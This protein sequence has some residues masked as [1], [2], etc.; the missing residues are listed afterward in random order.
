MKIDNNA[1]VRFHYTVA[2]EGQG[3]V[4]DSRIGDPIAVLIGHR[5]IIPGLEAALIGHEVGDR[6]EV[7]VS[8][9]QAYGMRHEGA[10]QRLSKKLFPKGAPLLPGEKVMLKTEHGPRMVTVKKVGMTVVDVD[11]NHP[12]AGMTLKFD[13]EIIDVREASDEEI[14][15]RHVHGEG[16]HA[17]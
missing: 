10:A 16:G 1:V 6:F 2:A 9:E 3:E 5:N 13:I 11:L 4:E 17:H 15:H 14:A 12:L 8:P 7:T